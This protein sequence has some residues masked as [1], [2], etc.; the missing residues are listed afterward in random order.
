MFW[1]TSQDKI[2]QSFSKA[3][4]I[5]VTNDGATILKSIG[6][7]N[8][9]AK[10]LVGKL[11]SSILMP[12]QEGCS[13]KIHVISQDRNDCYTTC[14]D[15]HA[16]RHNTK[17]WMLCV[18]HLLKEYKWPDP[19]LQLRGRGVILCPVDGMPVHS[20]AS[21]P[22]SELM[23]H[24]LSAYKMGKFQR[25]FCKLSY[26]FPL[27]IVELS[28]VQDNEVGDGTTSVTVLACELLRVCFA[29]I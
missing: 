7:D 29:S 1:F 10:I 22:H 9:A 11:D 2:L 19:K 5:Q 16:L 17:F 14:K 3:E 21:C 25:V 26:M 23:Y 6:V 28:K 13:C 4:E 27:F 8:P 15:M 18:A 24:L 20:I 12:I